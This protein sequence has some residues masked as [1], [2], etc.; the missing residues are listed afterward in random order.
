MPSSILI[1]RWWVIPAASQRL[2]EC[3]IDAAPPGERVVAVGERVDAVER[4]PGGAAPDHDIAALERDAPWPVTAF[5]AAEQE[6]RR[7]AERDRYDRLGKVLLVAILVQC[8][9]CARL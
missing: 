5:C 9:S 4:Q 2:A 6:H 3:Q 7:Q 1:R 8:Q